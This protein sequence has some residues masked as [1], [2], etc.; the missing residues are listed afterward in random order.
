M[1]FIIKEINIRAL[2]KFDFMP[3]FLYATVHVQKKHEKSQ[4]TWNIV[5]Q[6]QLRIAV[7]PSFSESFGA[8]SLE[9]QAIYKIYI[10]L[11]YGD[12]CKQINC[13]SKK[14]VKKNIGNTTQRS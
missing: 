4:Y 5:T 10:L 12:Q 9:M 8:S 13:L 6:I 14:K 3:C 1:L 7:I 2:G 11:G